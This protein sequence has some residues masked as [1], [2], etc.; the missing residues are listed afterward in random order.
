MKNGADTA[1]VVWY[2]TLVGIAFSIL[3]MSA[4]LQASVWLVN[5]LIR[6]GHGERGRGAIP[7]PGV[8]R[9]MLISLIAMVVQFVL[10]VLAAFLLDI[11]TKG[12][13]KQ[14]QEDPSIGLTYGVLTLLTGFVAWCVILTHTLPT[15]FNRAAFVTLIFHLIIILI[16]AVLVVPIVVGYL[17]RI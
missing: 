3:I 14:L 9:A 5:K 2:F 1:Q 13:E 17:L 4:L 10:N 11:K 15:S 7:A 12:A 8:R 16:V 6:P